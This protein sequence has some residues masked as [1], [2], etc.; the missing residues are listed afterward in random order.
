MPQPNGQI[1]SPNAAESSLQIGDVS[2]GVNGG[3]G[4]NVRRCTMRESFYERLANGLFQI[5]RVRP[6]IEFLLAIFTDCILP[7]GT[8]LKL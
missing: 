6:K 4:T 7:Y 8:T 5:F 2:P 1:V 3:S